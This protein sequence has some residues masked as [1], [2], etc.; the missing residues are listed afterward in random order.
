MNRNNPVSLAV[1][2]LLLIHFM[3]QQKIR[4]EHMTQT[5][6][7]LFLSFGSQATKI[8]NAQS[9]SCTDPKTQEE[10]VFLLFFLHS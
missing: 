1:F 6:G 8:V 9:M 4:M 5:G 7:G 2:F 3:F 10:I